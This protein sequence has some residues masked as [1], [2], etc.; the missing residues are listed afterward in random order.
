MTVR[1]DTGARTPI[2]RNH[3]WWENFLNQRENGWNS[4]AE[5]DWELARYNARFI[6]YIENAVPH[7][8]EFKS[9]E[10]MTLFLMRWS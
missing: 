8:V 2:M 4:Y 9:E 6:R 3:K 5:L 10:D 7:Q 1:I